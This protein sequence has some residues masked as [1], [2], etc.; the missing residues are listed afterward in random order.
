MWLISGPILANALTTATAG[1]LGDLYGHRRVYLVGIAGGAIF[2]AASAVAWDAGSLVAFRVLGAVIGSAAGPASMAMVNLMFA[3]AQR[4]TALGYWAL[5]GAGGPVVGL[6]VG[7]PLVDAFGWRTIFAAQVPF[8]VVAVAVAWRL[9]PE[10]T[11]APHAEFDVRGNIALAVALLS[12]LIGVERGRSW[13]WTSAPTLGS[14]SLALVAM[15]HF[16]RIEQRVA[17]PLIPV[18]YFRH[19]SF[20]V[21]MVVLFFAQF[22]YMGGFIL[23]PKLLAEI[24]GESATRISTLL[25]PRPLAF[26][27]AGVA[28]GYLVRHQGIRRI[29][30]VGIAL[31]VTSLTMISAV[32]GDL[33]TW[34]VLGAIAISGLG[35]GAAQPAIAASIANSVSDRDLGVAGA[36]NQMVAQ[37]A[38]SLGM[39]LLDSVQAGLVATSGLA[40]SYTASY[41]VGAAISMGGVAA[42]FFLPRRVAPT[43]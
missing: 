40:G 21:P 17:H 31:V 8:L 28:A 22:G 35:M 38:T 25:I 3:P 4:S 19:R 13:G 39:N 12:L 10:T 43:R 27:V 26:A 29:A 42:A 16:V 24:G 14:I 18:G 41:R 5:V 34:V 11:R 37:V 6:V 36:T 33:N 15:V 23:A 20:A 7:G 9:L 30:T 32:T 2:A 1:K